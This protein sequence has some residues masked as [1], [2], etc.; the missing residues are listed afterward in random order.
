METGRYIGTDR[1]KRL[2]KICNS[3]HTQEYEIHFIF[4]WGGAKL[5]LVFANFIWRNFFWGTSFD[6]TSFGVNCANPLPGFFLFYFF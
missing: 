5:Y 3:I 2:C 1:N 6:E 4:V